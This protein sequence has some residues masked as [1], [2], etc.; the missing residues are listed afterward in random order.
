MMTARPDNSVKFGIAAYSQTT[1]AA[2]IL[3]AFAKSASRRCRS[4]A[5]FHDHRGR[6]E[7]SRLHRSGGEIVEAPREMG[8]ASVLVGR[9]IG[10]TAVA[11]NAHREGTFWLNAIT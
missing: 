10:C 11:T 3:I 2:A 4:G 7:E 5:P 9:P 1:S 8:D 6:R